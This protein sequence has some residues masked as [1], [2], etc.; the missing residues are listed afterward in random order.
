VKLRHALCIGG[1]V[2]TRRP[3]T[4]DPLPEPSDDPGAEWRWRNYAERLINL[5]YD[6]DGGATGT[7]G[8]DPRPTDGDGPESWT[9]RR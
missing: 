3:S 2:I 4:P 7:R 5:G 8:S 9:A 1:A 6:L